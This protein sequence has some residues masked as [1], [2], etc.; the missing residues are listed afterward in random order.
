[1]ACY[2]YSIIGRRDSNEDK[3]K[4]LENLTGKIQNKSKINY[5][6]LFDGHGGKD[7]STFL[8]KYLYKYF[9]LSQINY[10][11]LIQLKQ[12]IKKVYD[13]IDTKLYSTLKEKTYKS[14]S[15]A[16]VLIMHNCQNN[17]HLYLINLGDCRAILCNKNNKAKQL[18]EDHKPN[19]NTEKKRISKLG[20]K[21]YYDGYDWRIE[22]L[23]V[24]RAFG[25]FDTKPYITHI[26][27]IYKI[28]INKDDKFVVLACDGLWDVMTNQ[29]V[30]N[31]ILN[32][33]NNKNLAKLLTQ[34][35][36][37]KGSTDNISVIIKFF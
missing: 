12:Y 8:A 22:N 29:E 25:D 3:H 17:L 14:G 34:E 5:Y 9:F 37:N 32:N 33:C 36:Y 4:I 11:N 7:V 16:L 21:I 15:T 1:M 26:P 13:K 23:S 30:V 2:S 10:N 24:S 18:T 6:S 28:K 20:G 19:T 27:E 31:F 35:A